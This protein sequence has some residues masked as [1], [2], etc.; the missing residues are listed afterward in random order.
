MAGH[1]MVQPV[2]T[3]PDGEF[4]F[5]LAGSH[6]LEITK[7]YVPVQ[8]VGQG[9]YGIVCAGIDQVTGDKV[10]I[11]KIVNSFQ[12]LKDAKQTLREIKLLRHFSGHENI[13]SL[14]DVCPPPLFYG[15]GLASWN[16]VYLVTDLMA[17]DLHRIIQSKQQLSEEHIQFFIYQTL[18]SLKFIHSGSVIHRD[19]KPSNLLVNEDAS[20]KVNS[21]TRTCTHADMLSFA[22]SGLLALKTKLQC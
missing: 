9:A 10:A 16:D 22:I 6:R 17:T 8:V 21:R 19:I 20:I 11:K 5:Y 14:K 4:V 13:I 1:V 2:G 3:S 18:K 7:R 12:N 15:N